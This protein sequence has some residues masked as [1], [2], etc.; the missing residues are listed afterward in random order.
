VFEFAFLPISGVEVRRNFGG[1]QKMKE[2]ECRGIP[3]YA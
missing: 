2:N 3:N 1:W